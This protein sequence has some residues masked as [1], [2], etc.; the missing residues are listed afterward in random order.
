VAN[1]ATERDQQFSGRFARACQARARG[2]EGRKDALIWQQNL[3]NLITFI[4]KKNYLIIFKLHFNWN[5][6]PLK[7]QANIKLPLSETKKI[8]LVLFGIP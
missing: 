3:T 7:I 6:S 2:R 4:L 5:K 8:T 1:N